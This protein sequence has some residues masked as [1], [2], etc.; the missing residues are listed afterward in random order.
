MNWK[1]PRRLTY[2]LRE[3]SLERREVRGSQEV[4]SREERECGRVLP[5]PVAAQ[6]QA[7]MVRCFAVCCS[8]FCPG[9]ALLQSTVR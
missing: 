3:D 5:L 4:S 1:R 9:C 8:L 6:C 2:L 7:S